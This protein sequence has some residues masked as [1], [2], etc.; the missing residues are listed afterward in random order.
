M[1]AAPVSA[2][3]LRAVARGLPTGVTLVT[4]GLG[5]DAHGTT[6]NSFTTVSLEPPLVSFCLG[7][8]TR[9]HKRITTDSVFVVSIL[10]DDQAHVARHCA[11]ATR[12]EGLV[13]IATAELPDGMIAVGAVGYFS[14]RVRSLTLL[15]DHTVVVGDV[16]DCGV[17]GSR[18]PLLFAGGR[19]H[20]LGS[21]LS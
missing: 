12:P 16:L 17:L 19:F 21:P 6:V 14:G 2:T 3:T 4:C 5:A 18:P 20:Q 8:G 7:H 1:T 11:D 15:G 10:A 13:G 9:L